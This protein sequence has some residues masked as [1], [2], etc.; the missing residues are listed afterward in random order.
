MGLHS[1]LFGP[2]K[3]AHPAA[4]ARPTEELVGGN[5]LVETGTSLAILLGTILGGVLIARLRAAL[6]G[7]GRR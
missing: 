7:A 3:Y 5:A 2:V 1:T 4:G 6:S